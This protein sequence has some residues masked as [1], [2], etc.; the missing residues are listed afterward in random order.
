MNY[1]NINNIVLFFYMFIFVCL[2]AL[3]L[4]VQKRT[5][6]APRSP[7]LSGSLALLTVSGTLKTRLRLRQVQRLIPQTAAMLSG[8]EWGPKKQKPRSFQKPFHAAEQ[9]PARG[10]KLCDIPRRLLFSSSAGCQSSA[11]LLA[12]NPKAK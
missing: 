9:H 2:Y 5:K 4:R 10:Y 12:D 11:V 6:R 3:F 1:I 8:T 7:D